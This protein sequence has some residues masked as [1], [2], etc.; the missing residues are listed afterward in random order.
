[1]WIRRSTGQLCADLVHGN[2]DLWLPGVG[3]ISR[4]P[5]INLDT[6]DETMAI[7]SLTIEQYHTICYYNLSR[8]QTITIPADVTA[9]SGVLF[10]CSSGAQRQNRTQIASFP[11]VEFNVR[12]GHWRGAEGEVMD[13][14][15]TRY[16]SCLQHGLS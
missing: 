14:G 13:S 15:W 16:V 8:T 10:L 11:D 1:M 2:S 12:V 7:E 9:N 6:I 3:E 5:G 4:S